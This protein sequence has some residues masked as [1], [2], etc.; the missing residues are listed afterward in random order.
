[1]KLN[2]WYQRILLVYAAVAS[3]LVVEVLL[4]QRGY[5]DSW[6]LQDIFVPT[7]L[8]ILT[9]S[10]IVVLVDNNKAIALVCAS[11]L[12]VLN[13]I[14]NLKYKFFYGTFDSVAHYGYVN[15]LVSLGHVPPTGFYANTYQDFPGM[16]IFIGSLSTVLGISTNSGM[17]LV[18]SMI[19]SIVP[20]MTYFATNRVFEPGIQRFMIVASGLPTFMSYALSGTA[21][22]LALYFCIV[23]L[24]LRSFLTENKRQY[25]V[26]LLIFV[27]GLLFSHAITTLYFTIFL[28]VVAFL[29]RF[30]S[31]IRNRS[32]KSYRKVEIP[33]LGTLI[34]LMVSFAARLNFESGNVLNILTE[35]GV[36]ILTRARTSLVPTTFFK[37]PLLAKVT[38]FALN[39]ANEAVI[40]LLSCA[41]AIVLFLKLGK[42]IRETSKEFHTFLLSLLCAILGSLTLQFLS[43][44]T[45]IE[46]DRLIAYGIALSPFL[47]GFLLWYVHK[48]FNRHRLGSVVVALLLFAIMSASILSIYPYQPA[49]PRANVLSADLPNN[50]YVYDFRSVNTVYQVN[51]IFFAQNF[52]TSNTIV[53]ADTVTRWQ[54][55]GFA[56]DAFN[57]RTLYNSPLDYQNL[58]WTLFLCHYDGKAGPLIEAVENRTSHRLNDI[59]NGLGNDVVY[60]NGQSFVIER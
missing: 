27:F 60:D 39:Y 55:A 1:M 18:T 51:L 54:I 19:M 37:V 6:I 34:I 11:F 30:L 23:C 21:F 31:I 15:N 35:A 26:V 45:G 29:L 57:S 17:K 59:K 56:S 41:G 12:V 44:F 2:N 5:Q 16:H 40:A 20:L 25:I 28:G 43:G 47:V 13:A 42:E 53:A 24:I 48:C 22:G 49:A 4:N 32:M 36:S 58:D 3:A 14:P 50:E 38:F 33:V 8:Y 10:V 7:I 52:S 46:Y 9:F